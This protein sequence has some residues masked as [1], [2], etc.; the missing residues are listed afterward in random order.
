MTAPTPPSFSAT[1][2]LHMQRA[3]ALAE[4]ALYLTSPNPR[5]GCVLVNPQ[6]QVIGEGHTQAAGQAHAEVMA[7]RQA[8]QQG[9]STQAATAYVT[10][11]PCSHHGRTPPCCDALI[12]AQV[13]RVVCALE[14]PF[15]AN[16]GQGFARLR[17][18]G[19]LVD[20]G[21]MAQAATEINIGFLH[22]MRTGRPWVRLKMAAS[23]D[24]ITAL[25]NGQSQ[26]IT[27]EAARA[28][29]HHWRARACAVCTGVGTVLEDDP[30][31]DVRAVQT[32]RQ[33]TLVVIDSRLQTP[34]QARLFGP[35]RPVWIAHAVPA[36]PQ[37]PAA[38]ALRQRAAEL[39]HRPNAAGKVSLPD[40]LQELGQRSINELHLEAGHLLN[41]SFLRESL[42][43]E[44]LLYQAPRM[45]GQGRGLSALGPLE[46]LGQSLDWRFVEVKTVGE[47]LRV[48]MMRA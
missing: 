20:V 25:P 12:Q 46:D 1:D 8:Q 19:L 47:D 48:R 21:L 32:P 35:K 13:A 17:A 39:I 22:R 34:T 43:D 31:L 27:G 40:L 7:L 45:L 41:T 23:I 2:A 37:S 4:S 9:H 28:D 26:W 15:P 30:Q 5:V 16:R 36:S 6:G 44:V 38:E 3:L 29:G 33:P 10:L 14:D 24:G 11:E 18:A 42:V